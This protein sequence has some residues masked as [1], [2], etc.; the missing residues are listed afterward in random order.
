[1]TRI[2]TTRDTIYDNCRVYSSEDVLISYTS[3]KKAL[4]LLKNQSAEL[5]CE[6]PFTIKLNKD[7][8]SPLPDSILIPR[9]NICV[10]CGTP[11]DLT[12]HHVIPHEYAKFMS[13]KFK[14][15]NYGNVL[16]VC[17]KCHQEYEVE[18]K[19]LKDELAVKYNAPFTDKD[20]LVI[21]TLCYTILNSENIPY[22]KIIKL[23]EEL[24]QF[25]NIPISE[26][27]EEYMNRQLKERH[28]KN[29]KTHSQLVWEAIKDSPNE[30]I[31]MWKMHFIEYAKP[32]HLPP[33]WHYYLD[34]KY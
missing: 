3:K 6:E 24:S 29:I 16:A 22:Q 13:V 33:F 32:Q 12:K 34:K 31:Y 18:A 5:I 21:F 19:K 17:Y 2:K 27:T 30:F 15:Y 8:K 9:E 23:Y 7:I 4:K 25:T 28:R 20:S 26:L 11:N 14:R 1:M 10:C